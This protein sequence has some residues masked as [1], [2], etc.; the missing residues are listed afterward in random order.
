M[1]IL[2]VDDV[3]TNR[4]LLA[5]ILEAEGH[6]VVPACDGAEALA[7]LE[8]R[9]IDAVISDILMPRM[10]GYRFCYEVR[11]SERFRHL[12][13]IFYTSSYTS[14][15]DE[16]LALEM[17]AD[18]FLTKPAPAATILACLRDAVARPRR[19]I[20]PA[21]PARELNLMKEYNQQLVAKLEQKNTE[22]SLLAICISELND[23]VVI[24]EA[25]PIDEPGPRVVFVNEAFEQITGHTSDETLG[26]SLRFLQGPLTDR[27][28]LR[29]IREALAHQEPIR[30]RLVNYR[31]N[32]TP[33]WVDMDIVPIFD[34]SG[35]CTHYAAIERDITDENHAAEQ[36][37]EQAAFLDK[38]RDAI[39]VRD[40]D[41]KILFWNKGAERMYGWTRDEA[42]GRDSMELLF[43][44][45]KSAAEAL[46]GTLEL[47]EW[48]GEMEI[49]T[50]DRRDLTVEARWTLVRDK[51]GHPKSI[52]AINTDVT[53]RKK[54]EAQFM[55]AQRMESIGTLAGGIAHDLNNILA[56]IM[57]SIDILKATSDNKQSRAILQTIET[58]AQRGADIVRQV[59]SFARG[60][61]G[62]RVEIQP[63]HL[64][65]DLRNIIRDT[66]PKDIQL[67]FEIPSE[68]WTILGDPTQLHQIL[69]NLSVNARDAMPR[70]GRL[71]IEVENC[72]I[73]QHYAAMNTQVKPGRYVRIEVTDSGTGIPRELR[74]KIFEPFFTTKEINKG[75]GLGLSTVLAIVKSHEG[76]I[77][78]YSELGRGTTFKV[79]L[80]A[81]AT[82]EQ[83]RREQIAQDE[84]PRGRGECILVVDDEASILTITSQTLEAFGYR[85]ITAGDGAE[86]IALYAR[87]REEIAVVLTDMMMPVMDGLATI[88]ALQHLNPAVKVVAA[89]GLSANGAVAKVGLTGVHHF[90]TK[91][92]TAATLL[93]TLRAILDE[94]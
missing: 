25:A 57:M 20:V 37:A 14:P 73:D 79:Y 63:G 4:K 28:T 10:D 92:Y 23:M 59:L 33:Y 26:R 44:S 70:G 50:R 5:A 88:H 53:E 94:P 18:I 27:H 12:P 1:R 87:Q 75:T 16:K 41:G 60:L 93:K 84:L 47:G 52:L 67:E 3:P 58:S 69:L 85:V 54:I 32:G 83:G 62:Q 55:R 72:E 81:L 35:V 89:S 31:K 78:V 77:N 68:P 45:A 71:R 38:A 82:S 7:L 34:V 65:N 30:R 11:V 17:G 76:V 24:T 91:P 39:L 2:I 64:L 36:I 74:E 13:F 49:L 40:L 19:A 15:S 22:L 66:F 43:P 48:N 61:E 90:L 8:H 42:L 46:A 6:E 80:P 21:E 56:P 9:E 51:E 29:E 86:A